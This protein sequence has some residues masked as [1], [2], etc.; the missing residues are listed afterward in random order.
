MWS[1]NIKNHSSFSQGK[2]LTN[3]LLEQQTGC[4]EQ[5][6]PPTPMTVRGEQVIPIG[7]VTSWT[8]TPSKARSP[9]AAAELAYTVGW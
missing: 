3:E 7:V 5:E 4:A 2:K 8:T 6:L 1:I 9:D